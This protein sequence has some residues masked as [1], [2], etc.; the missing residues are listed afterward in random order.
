MDIKAGNKKSTSRSPFGKNYYFYKNSSDINKISA[1]IARNKGKKVVVIQGLGFVGSAMLTAVASAQDKDNSPLYAVIG[2]DLAEPQSYWKVGMINGGK[3][4][5]K[6]IDKELLRVFYKSFKSGN[7]I[8]TTDKYVYSNADIIIIDIN[9]D[10]KKHPQGDIKKADVIFTDFIS[11]VREIAM[12]MKPD[13]LVIVESTVPVGTCEKILVPLFKDESRKRGYK[14]F[15]VNLAHSY[16]RVMPGRNYLKSIT[17]YYRVFSGIDEKSKKKTREFLETFIDTHTYPLTELHSTTA[18]EMGKILENSFR[19]VNIAFIQEWTEFAQLAGVNLYEVIAGI[20]KR[21]T[22]RNIMLPG[23]GVGGFCLPKD[24]LIGDWARR[25]VFGSPKHL[26]FSIKAV[27]VNDKM[28]LYSFNLLNKH[29]KKI[30]KKRILLMGVSYL[31]DV[32]DTRYSPSEIF[33]KACTEKGATVM[34]HDPIVNYWPEM[35]MTVN[36]DLRAIRSKSLDAMVIA[37]NHRNYLYMKIEEFCRLLKPS[38]LILDCCN[39]INDKKAGDLMKTGLRVVG[40]GKGHWKVT[41][42]NR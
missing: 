24:P 29:L 22:H 3:L 37:V 20:R 10:I 6:S 32:A 23:F 16:E 11:A 17:S 8:A 40:V 9:L 39:A 2:V 27:G 31:S 35:K 30:R 34:L 33:Y 36:N 18:S 28:P 42:D 14:N 15:K 5:V 38:G 25:K 21:D 4:P 19:A 13:C 26:D 12:F 7:I 1:F 41:K